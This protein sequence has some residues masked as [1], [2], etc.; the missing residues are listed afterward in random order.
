[1]VDKDIVQKG[2]LLA[3]ILH[4]TLVAPVL[5]FFAWEKNSQGCY[6]YP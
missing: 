4:S 6:F 3:D 1:M 5:Q 2:F